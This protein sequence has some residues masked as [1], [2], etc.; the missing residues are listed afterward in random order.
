MFDATRKVGS[1]IGKAMDDPAV[2][3]GF[4]V[5][6]FAIPPLAGV[7]AV[8]PIVALAGAATV[9]VLALAGKGVGLGV[10]AVGKKIEQ[11]RLAEER[12]ARQINQIIELERRERRSEIEEAERPERERK[13]REEKFNEL[14]S[15]YVQAKYRI[16][17]S[18]LPDADKVAWINDL[19]ATYHE[20][21]EPFLR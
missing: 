10:K 16:E 7:V 14:N 8:L 2:G 13:G 3:I 12:K 1:S 5:S 20:R 4:A 11:K 19:N 9:D 21:L 15:W 17:T 18:L 6:A